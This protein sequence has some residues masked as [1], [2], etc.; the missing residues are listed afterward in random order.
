MRSVRNDGVRSIAAFKR[1]HKRIM[2]TSKSCRALG[3]ALLQAELHGEQVHPSAG[4]SA[5]TNSYTERRSDSVIQNGLGKGAELAAC[6]DT[7]QSS[8]VAAP[9]PRVVLRRAS[10]SRVARAAAAAAAHS[11]QAALRQRAP[12]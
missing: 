7:S 10:I 12:R 8:S 1:G 6:K 3:Y 4:V 2:N 5:R 11:Q 9:L